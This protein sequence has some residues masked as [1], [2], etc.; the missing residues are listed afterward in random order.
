MAD[1]SS[2]SS[3]ATHQVTAFFSII[4]RQKKMYKFFVSLFSMLQPRDFDVLL[5]LSNVHAPEYRRAVDEMKCKSL[6][7]H[8]QKTWLNEL[9]ELVATAVKR[10]AVGEQRLQLEQLYM[11]LRSRVHRI[12]RE[13]PVD[14]YVPVCTQLEMPVAAPKAAPK[15]HDAM[16]VDTEW[17]RHDRLAYAKVSEAD[18]AAAEKRAKEIERRPDH[19]EPTR[20]PTALERC[21]FT[22]WSSTQDL[23]GIVGVPMGAVDNEALK[24]RKSILKED[25]TS[26]D[27]RRIKYHQEQICKHKKKIDTG[28]YLQD[29]D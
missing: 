21:Q 25:F 4:T 6:S 27:L 29:W 10:S 18:W 14:N 28:T 3:A 9:L 11:R 8:D 22:I 20:R 5:K 12:L 24:D 26:D 19:W 1:L 23:S 2:S 13:W 15:K 7:P 16:D 17:N